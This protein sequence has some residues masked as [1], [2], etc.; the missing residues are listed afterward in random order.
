MGPRPSPAGGL[1]RGAKRS[2]ARLVYRLATEQEWEHA[3]RAAGGQPAKSFNCRVTLGGSVMSGHALVPAASGSQV[4]WGLADH[5]GN[6]RE[7]VRAA[8]GIK[9]RGGNHQDPS[10]RCEVSL[11]PPRRT[12]GWRGGISPRSARNGLM[13]GSD[14]PPGAVA[15]DPFLVPGR[16]RI[17]ATSRW[18]YARS[19]AKIL[20]MRVFG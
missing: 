11:P 4:G 5:V 8:G 9:A 14:G 18:R 7:W 13:R 19:W 6:A 17:T 1:K 10:S 16:C 20:K 3:A 2:S 12:A 15:D